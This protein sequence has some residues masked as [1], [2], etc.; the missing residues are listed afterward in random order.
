MVQ[1]LRSIVV[2]ENNKK[3]IYLSGSASID[4]TGATV[5]IGDI[6]AQIQKVFEVIGALVGERGLV[7]EDAVEGTV[8]LKRPEYYEAYKDYIAEHNLKELPFISCIA[9][10]CRDD[11]LFEIDAIFAK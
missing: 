3:H 2:E 10:V 8:F 1:H 4:E 5:N 11:L 7:I 6:K 9:D